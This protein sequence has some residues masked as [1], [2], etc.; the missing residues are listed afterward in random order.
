MITRILGS[1]LAIL[2]GVL[3]LSAKYILPRVLK[4]APD[5]RETVLYKAVLFLICIAAAMLMILPDYL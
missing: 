4:R 1:V 3:A 2:S 5:E